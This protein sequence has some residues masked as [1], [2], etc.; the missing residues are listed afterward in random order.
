MGP[1]RSGEVILV[2]DSVPYNETFH[3]VSSIKANSI[4]DGDYNEF[5]FSRIPITERTLFRI[6]VTQSNATSG[7][8]IIVMIWPQAKQSPHLIVDNTFTSETEARNGYVV[9][10]IRIY[11]FHEVSRTHEAST[12]IILFLVG[13]AV[14]AAMCLRRPE[15]FLELILVCCILSAF[16]WL[17]FHSV[18]QGTYRLMD[19]NQGIYYR[20]LAEAF[21]HGHLG[22]ANPPGGGSD[23]A[24][25]KGTYYLYFGPVPALFWAV[26]ACLGKLASLE[27]TFTELTLLCAIANL[28][29]FYLLITRLSA[30]F[31]LRQTLSIRMIFLLVYGL[32][33]LYFVA[34]R[35]LVYETA[36]VFGSTFLILSS[37]S[38]IEY[39]NLKGNH[40]RYRSSLLLSS[41]ICLSLAFW[42]RVN[43]LFVI[44]PMAVVLLLHEYRR[45]EDV[46]RT[47]ARLGRLAR[48]L[49]PFLIPVMLAVLILGCYNA[50]RFDNPLDFGTT[51]M[52]V[53]RAQD[54]QRL[55]DGLEFSITYL[56]RNIY[57]ATLLMPS[58]S[59]D[60]PFVHYEKP[61]WLV[62]EYPRLT[63][64]EWCSSIFFS[65]PMLLFALCAVEYLRPRRARDKGYRM[66]AWI[67][68]G[69]L[70]FSA[71]STLFNM[72]Y[73]A[74]YVQ[75]YYPFIT[76][77]AF[78]GFVYFWQTWGSGASSWH[79]AFLV[80]AIAVI[81]VW[82][83]V[84]AF[85][86]NAQVGFL[87]DFSRALR[88]RN[89]EETFV[90]LS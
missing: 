52:L 17:Y 7:N 13:C 28:L 57:S 9:L 50:A 1:Q 19:Y 87:G 18:S 49:R 63:N 67:L 64:L 81:L 4:R 40:A 22:V 82:T 78:L 56:P 85:T 21:A 37:I 5:S 12:S 33:P 66:S 61:E 62:G 58:L 16:Y 23:W 59:S 44:I 51:H 38:L 54:A 73:C 83:S 77:L 80:S 65:S 60:A 47:A 34:A 8:E 3:R 88:I 89:S 79:K 24:L 10:A 39:V 69:F 70:L 20:A 45:A 48:T 84:I 43:L 75:D 68:A 72:G 15:R 27:A 42:S 32:G 86:L 76:S 74:R 14:A 35:F 29:A 46:P 55:Q 71:G 31:E 41:A 90:P 2:L 6:T 36:I 11:K 53:G 30:H 25:Y 26:F